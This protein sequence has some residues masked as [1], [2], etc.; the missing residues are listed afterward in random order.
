[1]AHD[2]LSEARRFSSQKAHLLAVIKMDS[3]EILKIYEK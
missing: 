2:E 1:M 3:K